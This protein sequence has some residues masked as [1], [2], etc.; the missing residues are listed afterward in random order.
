[1]T[2]EA[3]RA[4]AL[5]VVRRPVEGPALALALQRVTNLQRSR[6]RLQASAI[7]DVRDGIAREHM[8][9]F[10]IGL[11]NVIDAKS[12]YTREHSDRVAQR[13]KVFARH[14]NLPD[15]QCETIAFGAKL[16]DIGKV[17]VP[18]AIL[19][20]ENPLRPEER[21]V[22][23]RHPTD[24]AR[25]LRPVQV[26]H[27]II[28]IVERHHEN[29]DGSGYPDRLRGE[30][31]PFGA[32]L[33][34]LVDYYDAITS[35]RPYRTPLPDADACKVL[36]SE[37]GRQLDPALT[38]EFVRIVGSGLLASNNVSAVIPAEHRFALR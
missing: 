8:V 22:M 23:Q 10:M 11:A 17:A 28:P 14:L 13:A 31:I 5:D 1:V 36:L 35:K 30:E 34:K 21:D 6:H 19:N 7:A 15:A 24:G 16:H 26:L 12:Q 20:S 9:A 33:V 32:R 18:D 2:L 27:D 25:M 3:M 29:F 37:A 4:G 38:A